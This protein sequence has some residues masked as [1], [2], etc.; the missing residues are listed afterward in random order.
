L[1]AEPGAHRKVTLHQID[2][3]PPRTF[4]FFR[5]VREAPGAPIVVNVHGL[6]RNAAASIYPFLDEASRYGLSIVAPLFAKDTFGQYQQLI[7]KRSGV[8]SDLALL[9][10]LS[11]AGDMCA[12]DARRVLLFGFS[13]GAQ[14]AQRFTLAYPNMVTSV[15]LVAAGWY[16]M[17]GSRRAY[18]FG[19]GSDTHAPALKLDVAG[20]ARKPHHILVGE[21]DTLRDASLRR[22]HGL[23]AHQGLTRIERAQ[24]YFHAMS[25]I[26]EKDRGPAPT[27]EILDGVGHDLVST[28]RAADLPRRIFAHFAADAGLSPLG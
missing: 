22:S 5:P 28:V 7:D 27:F 2:E 26:A 25:N 15:A 3:A 12:A 18:P 24:T 16:T 9:E 13:G 20:A 8:R 6:S 21:L 17:P 23:D 4:F 19:V 10:M 1:T 11:A 14:F